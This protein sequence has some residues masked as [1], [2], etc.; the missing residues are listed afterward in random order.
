[1]IVLYHHARLDCRAGC[2]VGSEELMV[3]CASEMWFCAMFFPAGARELPAQF[4]S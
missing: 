2:D 3:I 1:M 4:C